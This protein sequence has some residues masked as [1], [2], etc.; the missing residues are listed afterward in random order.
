[1]TRCAILRWLALAGACCFTDAALAD[2]HNPLEAR[3]LI[4]AGWFF[5][6]SDT[7]V[8]V[9]GETSGTQGTDIDYDE[10]FGIGDADR[11]RGEAAWRFAKRHAI[12]AMYFE[13]NR[14]ATTN[15]SR[16]VRYGDETFPTGA[17]V[18][19]RSDFTVVQLAYDY[20]FL[21]RENY[22]VA[23]SFG[24]HMLDIDLGLSATVDGPTGSQ[25]GSISESATTTAPL[26]VVGLRGTWRL[27]YNF[28]VTAQA[29]YF[30]IKVDPYSGSL[31]D[32]KATLVW[33]PSD[34]FGIGVGYND[35]GFRFDL[36]DEDSFNGRLRWDYG[37]AMAFATFM[38]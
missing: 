9:D 29:Q 14:S 5:M 8:R 16:D 6:S 26:P 7:R 24:V 34:H 21:R 30:Y 22:E 23:G 20:A 12:R 36:D 15:L 4:E 37:G 18:T 1:M 28:Y 17:S 27:P 25:S 10:T 19:A 13:N 35:F 32:L 38:F 3:F 2:D 33:Q 11:F 31:T